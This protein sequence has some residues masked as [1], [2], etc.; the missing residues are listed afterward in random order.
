MT[1]GSSSPADIISRWGNGNIIA[2]IIAAPAAQDTIPEKLTSEIS[3]N[4]FA[5]GLWLRFCRAVA[6][7]LV[8]PFAFLE[9]QQA[10]SPN[11]C[12][13]FVRRD[14]LVK[15]RETKAG[16]LGTFNFVV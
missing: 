8:P 1:L 4:L 16:Q 5:S 2:F 15:L 3:R 10:F 13:Q 12:A 6:V 14:L 11:C 9:F 7:C